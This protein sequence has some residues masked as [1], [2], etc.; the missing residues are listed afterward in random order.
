MSRVFRK[1]LQLIGFVFFYLK[2]VLLSNIRIAADILTPR[3][4]MKPGVIAVPLENLT[5]PQ[6]LILTNLVSMTPGTLCLDVSDDRKVLYIHAMY[7]EDAEQLR[8]EIKVGF[9][10]KIL[11]VF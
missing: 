11:E 10:K 6:L 3:H 4:R 9:E 7:V 8:R 1:I 5:D 2:E